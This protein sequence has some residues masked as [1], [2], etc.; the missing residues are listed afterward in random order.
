M[1]DQDQTSQSGPRPPVNPPE[2]QDQKSPPEKPEQSQPQS[3][4]AVGKEKAEQAAKE[5]LERAQAVNPSDVTVGADEMIFV[6]LARRLQIDN[7]VIEEWAGERLVR[8]AR[9]LEF[10]E[11][12]KIASAKKKQPNGPL[13]EQEFILQS[14]SFASGTCFRVKSLADATAAIAELR[15]KRSVKKT[16]DTY[17]VKEAISMTDMDPET[18]ALVDGTVPR[19]TAG[20]ESAPGAM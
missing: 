13:N 18:Q 1:E 17:A 12:L 3:Q 6:S 4:P 8:P 20:Q 15:M 10:Q 9:P 16:I 5:S 11:N 19:E 14:N 2:S 7:W